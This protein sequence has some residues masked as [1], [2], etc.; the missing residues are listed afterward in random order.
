MLGEKPELR[1]VR[2]RVLHLR[3]MP[4][5]ASLDED[6]LVLIAED[7]ADDVGEGAGRGEVGAGPVVMVKV[8]EPETG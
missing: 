8:V 3:A 4:G 1:G 6:A 7:A 5:F 2:D